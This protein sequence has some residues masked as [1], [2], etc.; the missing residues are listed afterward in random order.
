MPFWKFTQYKIQLATSFHQM[1]SSHKDTPVILS[2][3][4]CLVHRWVDPPHGVAGGEEGAGH[5]GH[6]QQQRGRD[7]GAHREAGEGHWPARQEEKGCQCKWTYSVLLMVAT[8]QVFQEI[9]GKGNK[10]KDDPK[11]PVFLGLEVKRASDLWDET[12]KLAL[13]RLERLR[14][15][16]CRGASDAHTLL[17]S[18]LLLSMCNKQA[19]GLTF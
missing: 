18:Q 10:L 19:A 6:Q 15:D 12:N 4:Y 2:Y 13:D 16:T 8:W 3:V 1:F 14:G 7:W 17:A 9:V 5:Q 11:C